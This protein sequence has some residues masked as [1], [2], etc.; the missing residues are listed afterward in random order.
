MSHPHGNMPV[1]TA[2]APLSDAKAV[3]ILIH[4]RGA[5]A[6]DILM[7]GLEFGRSDFALIAPEAANN[8][9]Y[10]YGFMTPL[11]QNDPHLTSALR[12]ISELITNLTAQGFP[13]E[14]LILGGFSQGACLATEYAA[15]NATRYGGLFGF[16]GGLIGPEG[17]PRDYPGSF[18]GTPAFLGCSDVDFHIP[19]DRVQ[20]TTLVL[21]RM[22][23]HVTE[24]LYPGMGHTVNREEL[25]FVRKMMDTLAD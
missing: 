18:A 25:A 21:A 19:K 10:P 4:G 14:K 11:H 7:L 12:I 16:S 8:T 22:D 3:M 5:S 9:W 20:E 13:P 17:T 2:G 1:L 24:R 6:R 23:A 15:R